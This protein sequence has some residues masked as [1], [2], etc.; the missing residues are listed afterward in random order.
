MN[1]NDKAYYESLLKT[2]INQHSM[3]SN[4]FYDLIN[5]GSDDSVI[6]KIKDELDNTLREIK[7]LRTNLNIIDNSKTEYSFYDTIKKE[8]ANEGDSVFEKVEKETPKPED[9]KKTGF[10]EYRD[11][12]FSNRFLVDLSELGIKNEW[13]VKSVDFGDKN[14]LSK[15][16]EISVTVYDHLVNIG[17]DK[18]TLGEILNDAPNDFSFKISYLDP[19]GCVIYDEKYLNCRV[20]SIF[21]SSL[22]YSFNEPVVYRINMT[23]DSIYSKV[24]SKVSQSVLGT[25]KKKIIRRK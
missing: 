15:R 21:R 1:T 14:E 25:Q 13:F 12:T 22:D 19:T 18:Y 10:G 6:S 23:Y 4:T 5:R 17:P 9:V 11:V 2:K 20:E 16:T 7:S 3:L 24:P 8:N